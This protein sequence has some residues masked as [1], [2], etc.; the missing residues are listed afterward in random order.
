MRLA[1]NRMTM[2]V[3]AACVLGS[4]GC[5][6]TSAAEESAIAARKH[7][8]NAPVINT[9]TLN[10]WSLNGWSLNGVSFNG[11]SLNGWSLNGW[12]LNGVTLEGSQFTGTQTILGVQEQLVGKDLIGAQITLTGA[13][14]VFVLTIDDISI[15]QNNPTGDVYLYDVSVHDVLANVTGPLCTVDGAP[16]LAIPLN[17]YWDPVTGDRDDD[18]SI[19]TFACRGGAL[20]KCVDWG[21]LPWESAL[22]CD[23]NDCDEVQLDDL[24]QACTRMVRADYCGDGTPHTLN[25]TPIDIFDGL[26]P[27]I[28]VAST[29]GHASWGIE[30]E[31]GPDGAVCIGEDLRLNMFT[32]LGL[33]VDQ[34]GCLEALEDIPGCG[35]LDPSRGGV[36]ADRF[37]GDWALDPGACADSP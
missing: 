37:C 31:W 13:A 9:A 35:D 7:V 32:E 19:V 36:V 8:N 34:P 26:S 16:A 14:G 33:P 27:Q 29:V 23:G 5:D 18:A 20:A 3:A 22:R 1:M 2:L 15:D 12:S 30:A 17:N 24:H 11:W 6:D 10:G 25:G 4:G 28:Q 21:Y